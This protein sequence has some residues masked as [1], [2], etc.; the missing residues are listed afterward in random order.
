MTRFFVKALLCAVLGVVMAGQAFAADCPAGADPAFCA[1]ASET[2]GHVLSG[3]PDEVAAQLNAVTADRPLIEP[4][5]LLE[6]LLHLRWDN[7]ARFLPTLLPLLLTYLLL[8][9]SPRSPPFTGLYGA[10]CASGPLGLLLVLFAFD[11]AENGISPRAGVF[12][13][14]LIATML[15]LF[16][17]GPVMLL[18]TALSLFSRQNK[19]VLWGG[20]LASAGGS[21]WLA[22]FMVSIR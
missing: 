7:L 21:L 4:E 11:V 3:S 14:L 5:T 16:V 8:R 19:Y 2:G 20:A 6:T 18:G 15:V 17:C 10:A 12:G 9:K 13:E 1:L 22:W